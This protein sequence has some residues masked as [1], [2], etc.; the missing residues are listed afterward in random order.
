MPCY[1]EP[2]KGIEPVLR[3]ASN[4]PNTDDMIPLGE[5]IDFFTS[6]KI[7]FYFWSGRDK[8]RERN[9]DVREKH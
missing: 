7:L 3:S 1:F 8:E 6:L 2:C 4:K 5:N 9:I